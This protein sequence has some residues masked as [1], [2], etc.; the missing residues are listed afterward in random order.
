VRV[1]LSEQAAISI[2][3]SE[4]ENGTRNVVKFLLQ[5]F[6][7]QK[8]VILLAAR[9]IRA[10]RINDA[11]NLYRRLLVHQPNHRTALLGLGRLLL[12]ERRFDEAV[13]VLQRAVEIDPQ[14]KDSQFQL[15]RALHRS[16]R[17]EVAVFQYLRV[18]TLDPFHEKALGALE[19]LWEQLARSGNSGRAAIE[20]TAALTRQM[21]AQQ[22]GSQRICNNALSL[23]SLLASLRSRT[24]P[25]AAVADLEQLAILSPHSTEPPLQIA[26]IRERQQRM[27]DARHFFAAVLDRNPNHAEALAGYG[28]ALIEADPSA[29][30]RHFTM[31]AERHPDLV[32]PRL[33]LA[34]LYQIKQDWERV[35][36][37]HQEILKQFPNDRNA[38]LRLARV[39]S[40]DP[41]RIELALDLWRKV[42]ERD[43]TAPLPM[44]QRAYIFERAHRPIEAEAEYRAALGRA[45]HEAAALIGLARLL[46]K[47]QR[48]GEAVSLYEA[49]HQVSP[50]RTDVLLGL[51]R[52]LERLDQTVD[53]LNTYDKV[54]VL[55]PTDA[56]AL[57]YRGRLLRQIGRTAEAI[58][59]W[60][61][62]CSRFPHNADAWHELVFLLASAERDA[63]A[64][65]A[66]DAAETALPE[67]PTSWTRLGLAA[68]AAQFHDRAVHYFE[69]AIAAEPQ[70]AS[71]HGHLGEHYARQGIVDGAFHHLLAS[72][73]LRP[74]DI[75]V[76]KQLVRTIH[77]LGVLGINP[78]A[79]H[80]AGPTS[81]E[82]LTPESLFQLVRQIAETEIVPYEPITRRVIAVSASLAGGG[83]E[84]QLVNLLRG[85]SHPA[86]DLELALFCT[87]LARRT[88]RDFFLPLLKETP[89]EVVTAENKATE[90]WLAQP[91][92]APFARLIRS[93]PI[94]MAGPIAFWLTEFRRR[95]PQV[96]HAWQDSTSLTAVVAALLAGVPR[97][98]LAARS[99][100]PD[101]PRRRLKRFMREGYRAV[102]GHPSVVLSNNSRAGA[103]DYAKWLDIDAATIEVVYNGI[104]VDRLACSIDPDR[105]N[106]LRNRLGIPSQ[107][108][109]VGS[110]FRMS[111]EKRPLLWV[112]VAAEVA[113]RQPQAHF[114]VYGDGPMRA[115]MLNLAAQLG[116]ADRLHLPAPE[117]DIVSFYKAM[118]VVLL[119]SRHEG[120]PNVLLEAQSLG[121]PVVAP[122]VG[123]IGEAMRSGITGWTANQAGPSALAEHV[124]TCLVD[125]E[126]TA[127]ARAEG[128]PF[129]RQRFGMTAMIQRTL[130]IY[131]LENSQGQPPSLPTSSNELSYLDRYLFKVMANLLE[132]KGAEASGL[133]AFYEA[134]IKQDRCALTAYD[135]MLF[136]YVL[137]HFDRSER[138]IVHAGTG[139]GTLPSA[140]AVAGYSVAGVEC[141]A[142]RFRAAHLVRDALAKAW[143][144]AADQYE[145]IAGEFPMVLD[146]TSWLSPSA[147]LILT[148]CGA[149][150]SED[151]TARAIASFSA[152]ADIILDARL[153]GNVRETPRERQ[154]LIEQIEAE[155]LVATPIAQSPP[156]TF[157]YHLRPQQGAQ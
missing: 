141:D 74:G 146:G 144:T 36:T 62:I 111:E 67:S 38:L 81:G 148:N 109:I 133:Y 87:S 1:K 73:E 45:P 93:F 82:V 121:V 61:S 54:L 103:N 6:N 143:P 69:R 96:V 150:W 132:L 4:V 92:A 124:L 157:Y 83:A 70:E 106:Q 22:T 63:E 40:R 153:F 147:V 135:R 41:N 110:A 98:V 64:L 25:D 37:I 118:D 53:A 27:V 51:G 47:Q 13:D 32:T 84:R 24:D 88:R 142:L 145:L 138:R 75:D 80:Q 71:H 134:R 59:T 57:L 55:A 39:L 43:P 127:K 21:L 68:Q 119:T 128:P 104:D 42:A 56:N 33:E 49:A 90:E 34:R 117:D 123:G 35:E 78:L 48:W 60:R 105:T 10:S 152:F 58:D 65:A 72:R 140:L 154:V 97:I 114:V 14:Y 31:W 89:I 76:T 26:R 19:Q 44:V 3:N 115:D 125:K 50:N 2:M 86:L 155:G 94:D 15:A 17:F 16:R 131:G 130:E 122:D 18:L 30:I 120:L 101:N 136:D 46:F 9:H 156:M 52:C 11:E 100:R 23:M 91:E 129:V 12:R 112:E 108:S 99:L 5:M 113:H 116:I 66:L 151:L 20:A 102:L 139:I 7:L 79:L 137:A 28:R 77:T 85:L 95:R 107:A 149:G 8:W 29:A 126:W